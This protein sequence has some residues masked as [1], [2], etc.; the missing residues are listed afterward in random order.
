MSA[1]SKIFLARTSALFAAW[2]LL[3]I[4][5]SARAQHF[6]VSAELSINQSIFL[7]DEDM[8]VKVHVTNRSGQTL[9][10]GEGNDWLDVSIQGAEHYS[11]EKR[12][13]IPL[14]GP[15]SL[16]TGMVATRRFN[17][18]PYFDIR[19]PGRYT[20][21]AT[22]HIPQW[23][24]SVPCKP[25]T[26]TVIEGMPLPGLGALEFGLPVPPGVTNA[27]PEIRRY[28]LIK[29]AYQDELKLYFRLTDQ[30]GQTLR[31]SQAGPML[32]FSAPEAQI[33]H[34]NNLHVLWQ[35]GAKDFTYLVFM[36]NGDLLVRETHVY[37]E[38]RPR[39][40]VNENGNVGVGGGVRLYNAS[41]I[42]NS[43]TEAARQ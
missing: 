29:V 42:P 3:F 39:L 38:T 36:P 30:N 23:N 41:D 16:G 32:S 24:E 22:V 6:G 12:G 21:N 43:A 14:A 35:T 34:F 5:P 17:P 4:A 18:A 10:L 7:A 2:C 11:P 27:L 33:D 28:A 19:R 8:Q 31:C 26:F 9:A 13:E 20:L 25:V 15:F 1:T 37:T 40:Q